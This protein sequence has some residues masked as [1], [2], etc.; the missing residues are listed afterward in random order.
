MNMDS[1]DFTDEAVPMPA[2]DILSVMLK[3]YLKESTLDAYR[4]QATQTADIKTQSDLRK[5]IL[6]YVHVNSL[7][8]TPVKSGHIN[9]K[10]ARVASRLGTDVTNCI[11]RL[12]ENDHLIMI[13]RGGKYGLISKRSHDERIILLEE[14]GDTN[15][16]AA[17][18]N[19]MMNLRD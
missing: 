4:M 2:K 13:D 11:T 5:R 3:D 1:T 14:D 17:L 18:D 10:F 9:R 6:E 12:I 7:Q 15:I 16:G 19:M 8:H